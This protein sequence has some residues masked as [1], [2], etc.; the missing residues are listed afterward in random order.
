VTVGVFFNA[1]GAGGGPINPSSD[2]AR[3]ERRV[4]TAPKYR[5]MAVDSTLPG[6]V[7][8]ADGVR[9]AGELYRLTLEV[10]HQRVVPSEPPELELRTLE[11]E[12]GSA[13]LAFMLRDGVDAERLRD[14]SHC[15]GWLAYL[16]ERGWWRG[17]V[18]LD[19]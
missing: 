8:A 7:A 18:R 15:G 12:D 13:V 3:F 6:L 1:A 9:L 2:V 16:R 5:L 17:G 14:V 19:R 10:L 11:L 4:W